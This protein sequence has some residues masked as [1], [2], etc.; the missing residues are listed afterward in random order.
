MSQIH[1][2]SDGNPDGSLF[3]QATTDKIG[4]Y[5]LAA[6]IV[7]PTA[8]ICSSTT[9]VAASVALAVYNLKAALVALGLIA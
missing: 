3:G 9:T 1:Q 6:P 8:S 2:V 4:F 7:Q 5:G